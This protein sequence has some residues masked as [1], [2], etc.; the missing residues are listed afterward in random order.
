MPDTYNVASRP[1]GLIGQCVA[2][3]IMSWRGYWQMDLTI[4]AKQKSSWLTNTKHKE[5]TE[6]VFSFLIMMPV[7][8]YQMMW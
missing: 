2:D 3:G 4:W 8:V 7:W 6:G 1:G 5:G